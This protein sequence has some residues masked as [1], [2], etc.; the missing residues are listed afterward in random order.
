MHAP[1]ART[2]LLTRL[3]SEMAACAAAVRA[4]ERPPI[5][6][7][8]PALDRLLPHGGVSR[9]SLV[10][11]PDAE[12][13]CGAQTVAAALTA[14]AG[15]AG[16]AV[17]VIDGDGHFYPPGLAAWGVPLARLV[18]VRASGAAALWAA[19]QALRCPAVAAVWLWRARLT[20]HDAQRLRLAA[21]EGGS[22][23]ILFRA[24]RRA[25]QSGTADLQLTV[26]PRPSGRG[27]RLR[28]AVTRC[29]G[30]AAGEAADIDID[31]G[32]SSC[33]TPAVPATAGLAHPA[34]AG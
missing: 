16:G 18:D 30:G 4:G 7:G 21:Q 34:I 33:E 6:S 12:N 3:R 24:D 27:R 2:E 8:W 28:V 17:V 26:E 14:Q 11:L 1:V 13:G 20:P 22:L 5:P 31:D 29:R 32:G 19:D 9:G 15:R 25:G 23:G 10:E